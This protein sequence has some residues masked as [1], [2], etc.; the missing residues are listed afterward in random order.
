MWWEPEELWTPASF[1]NVL[2]VPL[3]LCLDRVSP[4]RQL[5]GSN[6]YPSH[7]QKFRLP[8]CS[9]LEMGKSSSE[10]S[11]TPSRTSSPGKWRSFSLVEAEEG[12]ASEEGVPWCSLGTGQT[13]SMG[14]CYPGIWTALNPSCKAASNTDRL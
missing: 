11:E 3:L 13:Q 6:S 12:S 14:G 8:T 9:P 7:G 2:F 5:L 4:L 1:G 10:G